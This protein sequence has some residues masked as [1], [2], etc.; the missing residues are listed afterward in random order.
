MISL[1][2][3]ITQA[4]LGYF[5]LHESAEL[6][7]NEMARLLS[8]DQGNLDRKLKELEKEG[9]LKSDIRGKERY[10]SLNAAF[11]LLQE[12]KKI[13]LKTIGLEQRLKEVLRAVNGIEMSCL[14][15]SYAGDKMDLSSDIDLLVVGSHSVIELQR[16]IAKIQKTMSR[17][18]NVISMSSSE[19]QEKHN[20]DALLKSILRKKNIRLL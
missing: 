6:Y 18:L 7:V 17:E 8:L 5:M 20:S 4:V 10:Y 19:Y 12:Y 2:S 1:R 11:P 13:V 16:E 14:F 3:K 15:G 9:L